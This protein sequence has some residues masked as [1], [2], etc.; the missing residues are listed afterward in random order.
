[1]LHL[2]NLIEFLKTHY[3][4]TNERLKALLE[5]EEITFELL[6]VFFR[7]NSLVFMISHAP[8]QPKC[9]MFDSG[10]VKTSHG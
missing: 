2:D 3:A 8:E 6:P 10:E 4:S 9:L 5:H 1:M 7:P